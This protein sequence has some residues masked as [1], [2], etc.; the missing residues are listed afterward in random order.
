LKPKEY[1]NSPEMA[2]LRHFDLRVAPNYLKVKTIGRDPA[3][4][5]GFSQL[6]LHHEP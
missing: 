4:P 1:R 3:Q 6:R 5:D 2:C